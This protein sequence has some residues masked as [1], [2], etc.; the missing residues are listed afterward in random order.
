MKITVTKNLCEEYFNHT[1]CEFFHI[2]AGVFQA[3][4]IMDWDAEDTFYH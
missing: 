1:P 4:N 2:N 3:F